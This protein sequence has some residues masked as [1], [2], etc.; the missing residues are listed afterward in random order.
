V[1]HIS[2]ELRIPSFRFGLLHVRDGKDD[3]RSSGPLINKEIPF[4]E[5][6]RLGNMEA[7]V[8][9]VTS[10]GFQFKCYVDHEEHN[11]GE[12]KNLL[13][14]A[15]FTQVSEGAGRPFRAWFIL[16]GYTTYVTTDG[17][18]DNFYYPS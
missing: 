6:D 8:E 10:L 9:S 15:G 12:L 14:G 4:E 1:I 2:D 11:F 17:I 3:V 18:T 16:P 5:I 13:E 7:V